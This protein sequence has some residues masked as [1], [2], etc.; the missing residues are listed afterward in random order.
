MSTARPTLGRAEAP[1]VGSWNV[2]C[3]F[4]PKSA[5]LSGSWAPMEARNILVSSCPGSSHLP[6]L[7]SVGDGQ[8]NTF[9]QYVA[10]YICGFI[11]CKIRAQ[12]GGGCGREHRLVEGQ[13]DAGPPLQAAC[14]RRRQ[15][16]PEAGLTIVVGVLQDL[17]VA[18]EPGEG[19]TVGMGHPHF[20]DSPIRREPGVDLAN[21]V[22]DSGA[23]SAEAATT[24]A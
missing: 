1:C 7:R 15:P 2:P 3:S 12:V 17:A 8:K 19:C 22:L 18:V 11:L 5:A 4:R 24:L 6:S 16:D 9:I 14:V 10:Y 23:V 20:D 21:Q 13:R